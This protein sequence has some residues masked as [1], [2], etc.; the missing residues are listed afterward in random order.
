MKEKEI[1]GKIVNAL[2]EIEEATAIAADNFTE[3]RDANMIVV[4]IEKTTQ[5]NVGLPDYEY[6]LSIV[7]DCFIEDDKDAEVFNGIEKNVR[8]I[9]DAYVNREKPLD[10]LF[11]EIPVV[12]FFFDDEDRMID[13]KSNRAVLYCKII[14]SF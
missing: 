8:R 3:E 9:V 5:V 13:D 4:G 11:E 10:S 6:R 2:S 7:I 1:I 14:A 12:G